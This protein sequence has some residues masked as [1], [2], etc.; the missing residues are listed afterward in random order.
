MCGHGELPL[1]LVVDD[2]P[3]AARLVAAAL[4]GEP[5]R[6]E[7]VGSYAAARQRLA[8]ERPAVLVVEIDLPDGS[9][10][11]LIAALRQEGAG[12]APPVV[13]STAQV[14]PGVPEAR[15]LGVHWLPK[16]FR[17]RHARA[18]LLPLLRAAGGPRGRSE[19]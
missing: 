8:C 13:V 3:N 4:L 6:V 10:W 17:L 2:D 7:Q 9:G 1:V 14:R 19:R 11:D 16:P 18:L 12:S 15:G 5:C